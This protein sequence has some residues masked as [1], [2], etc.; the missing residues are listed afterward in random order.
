MYAIYYVYVYFMYNL[1]EGRKAFMREKRW[2][3]YINNKYINQ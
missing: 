3:K 2:E 1:Q